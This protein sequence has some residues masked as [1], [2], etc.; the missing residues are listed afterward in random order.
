MAFKSAIVNA[1]KEYEKKKK[2]EEE[3]K[4]KL[5]Y[6]T[7][8]SVVP[9]ATRNKDADNRNFIGDVLGNLSGL[10]VGTGIA[11]KYIS[12]MRNNT[13]FQQ[14]AKE[15]GFDLNTT[16]TPQENLNMFGADVGRTI[17]SAG[18]G[19][20][21]TAANLG[22]G[23]LLFARDMGFGVDFAD[24]ITNEA[25]NLDTKE[26]EEYAKKA[27]ISTETLKDYINKSKTSYEN[28]ESI[29]DTLGFNQAKREAEERIAQ[30]QNETDSDFAKKAIGFMPNLSQQAVNLA[31]GVI[32]P[33]LVPYVAA[34]QAKGS[35]FD[36]AK[37]RGMTDEQANNFS[38][39]MSGVEALTEKMTVKNLKGGIDK[40]GTAL[41]GGTK[42]ATKE[43]VKE[44]TK[45]TVKDAFKDLFKGMGENAAQEFST[46]LIQES[47][48]DAVTGKEIS[49][50]LSDFIN[51]KDNWQGIWGRAFTAGIQGAISAGISGGA[52]MGIKS[53]KTI[54][55]NKNATPQQLISAYLDVVNEEKTTEQEAQLKKEMTQGA[56][57]AIQNVEKQQNLVENEQNITQNEQENI[58]PTET[59]E[60]A[61]IGENTEEQQITQQENEN[62]LKENVEPQIQEQTQENQAQEEN[63]QEKLTNEENEQ[64]TQEKLTS[65]NENENVQ[66]NLTEE[67][68]RLSEEQKTEIKKLKDEL[69]ETRELTKKLIQINPSQAAE[70]QKG[71]KGTTSEI[72]ARIREATQGDSLIPVKGGLTQKELTNKI[73]RLKSN[74]IGKE[75]TVDGKQGK[76]T[77]NAFGKVGVQFEDGSEQFFLSKELTPVQDIDKIISEQQR[78]Q[79]IR[80]AK[81]KQQAQEKLTNEIKEK[82]T[83][84]YGEETANKVLE[85]LNQENLTQ[86]ET[87]ELNNKPQ[88]DKIVEENKEAEN[89]FRRLQEESRE[90]PNREAEL[91]HSSQ[92]RIDGGVQERLSNVLKG[93]LQSR[94]DSIGYGH[95]SFVNPDSNQTR[96]FYTD[97]DAQSFHDNMEIIQ[98]YLPYGDAVD[99]HNVKDYETTKN[100]ISED[101]LSGFAITEDGDLIS[102]YNLGQK[103]YLKSIAAEVNRNAKTLDCYNMES[104]PLADMY[105][106]TLGW[107]KASEMDFSY[108]FLVEEKGKEYADYFVKTYGEPP[109]VFMVKT[110]QDVQTKHFTGDQYDEAL[111]YRNS[112]IEAE[113]PRQ[114]APNEAPKVVPQ[115]DVAKERNITKN[116]ALQQD[117]MKDVLN[118]KS[119]VDTVERIEKIDPKK[120]TEK[121]KIF[122]N[123]AMKFIDKGAAVESLSKR[124]RNRNLEAMWDT[125]LLSQAKAQYAIGNK[126]TDANGNQV[127]SIEDLRNKL[128][129]REQ[130]EK[131]YG[132]GRKARKQI[133][134]I[135]AE[136]EQQFSDYMYHLLNTDRMSLV[137][138]GLATENK[139]VFGDDVTAEMSQ[140]RIAEIEKEHPEFKELA[141]DVYKYLD[142][143]LQELV[144]AGVISEELKNTFKEMYPHYVPISRIENKGNAISVP[145]DTKR[146][147]IGTPIK[148]AKGG[149]GKI[150][151][152]FQTMGDRTQQIYRAADRNRFGLELRNTYDML[153]E[154]NSAQEGS[155]VETILDSIAEQNEQNGVQA[156]DTLPTFTAF[157]NG[158]KVTFEISQD[159]YNSLRPRDQQG[160]MAKIDNS[161]ASKVIRKISNFR[162]GILTEYNPVFALTNAIKDAQDVLYNSQHAMKTYKN[163]PEAYK[164]IISKGKYYQEYLENG[165][166][167]NSYYK[168]GEFVSDKQVPGIKKALMM[169]IDTIANI[170]E[171][172]ETAPRL[173]EYIA[174]RD[175]GKSIQESM[176]DAARVT[177]NFKAGGDFTKFANRNGATFLN[178]SVQGMAQNVRNIREAHQK[179]IKGYA[180]LLAK[181][182][183]AGTPALVLNGLVWKDDDDYE[184]LSDYVKDNYYIVGKV[185]DTFIRVPKGRVVAVVQDIVE[186]VQNYMTSDKEI[187]GTKVAKD[188]FGTL[189]LAGNNLAPNNPLENNVL[190]PI[191][192]V[193]TN[194]TWYGDDLVPKR[195]QNKPA[196]EQYDEKTDEFSKMIGQALGISPIKINYLLDQYGGGI[197]DILLPMGTPQAEENNLFAD[198]F[199][200]DA[201][202]KNGNPGKFYSMQEDIQKANNSSNA[203]DTDKLKY[204]YY[205]KVS[206][207]LSDLY[208]MKREIQMSDNTD[209]YKKEAIKDVQKKINDISKEAVTTLENYGKSESKSSSN[210][211]VSTI[212]NYTYYKND[213]GELKSISSKDSIKNKSVGLADETYA[214]YKSE[215]SGVSDTKEKEEILMKGNYTEEEKEKLY[216]TYV[217]KSDRVYQAASNLDDFDID[218]YLEYKANY[219]GTTKNDFYNYMDNA[220]MP[221]IQKLYI[222]G[223]KYKLTAS[224]RNTL[225]QYIENLDISLD[226]KIDMFRKLKG[227]TV[228][229][230]GQLYY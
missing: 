110:N 77:K 229:S 66:E 169:P 132:K 220:D 31:A 35:Y 70:L 122:L 171:V 199:T 48:A 109:V 1:K 230:D 212:G 202:M 158:N 18:Q 115:Q 59:N 189:Q 184:E 38:T 116:S 102:V 203:T 26:L 14:K 105:E 129:N 128:I 41:K 148:A 91:Y 137:E 120:R 181:T 54:L 196:E 187:D 141:E 130:L 9:I 87:E 113:Q 44:T 207:E 12:D 78:E 60:N 179:G 24:K 193:A 100:Y 43:A 37:E 88:N 90:M 136:R 51:Q 175:M 221:Y 164:Q 173:A 16:Y 15:M 46:E 210:E 166:M 213:D 106:K 218:G 216:G 7:A 61:Q 42:E 125:M 19:L 97:V 178:A 154:L 64:K 200:V 99:V 83:K 71:L 5:V 177:T 147:G 152:L 30:L 22:K 201:T 167:Q 188:L 80:D 79:D 45:A 21:S 56:E 72:S 185:G 98:K 52:G 89:E 172:I 127:D 170:N 222:T 219:N 75:V 146:T 114:V 124:A 159:I 104:Q 34:G 84:Q 55:Q 123:L 4:N 93:E 58:E 144:D 33:A 186:N 174:S 73:N 226:D 211:D 150:Q 204:K 206:G 74:Y 39:I 32:N 108:D 53:C 217:N 126:R 119:V 8:D 205:N 162:R 182:V 225:A 112:F 49:Q 134:Q 25:R 149:D 176:L 161:K 180:T 63:V 67:E 194:K 151:S 47:V 223:T 155:S 118:G 153:G 68:S 157:E 81:A 138:R 214:K 183:I 23:I 13:E 82:V 76:I 195:L 11:E 117:S 28:I 103:G 111:N 143:D 209:E 10:G 27:N 107:K 2:E 163:F 192:N 96:E 57:T 101:G 62:A 145:L 6:K 156:T 142:R 17:E 227:A 36:D 3:L 140:E 165:G 92:K 215:V 94:D 139:A 191:V 29:S 224:E 133:D 228:T 135:A 85:A 86:N 198:K 168:D 20:K 131:E 160:L 40:I 50:S 208:K 121:Q 95:T 65:E 190:S 197:S 69:K